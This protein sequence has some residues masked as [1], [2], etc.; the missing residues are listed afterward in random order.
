M[1]AGTGYVATRVELTASGDPDEVEARLQ[2]A[3]LSK[4]A[5]GPADSVRSLY[6]W[7]GAEVASGWP[8]SPSAWAASH[9]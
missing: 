3:V 5:A 6:G 2:S 7:T 4:V 8:S 1:V 9:A